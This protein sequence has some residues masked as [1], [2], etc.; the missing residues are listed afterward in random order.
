ML[1]LLMGIS[2]AN[3]VQS[4]LN[5]ARKALKEQNYDDLA[6]Q[7]KSAKKLAGKSTQILT[8]EQVSDIWFL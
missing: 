5:N 8:P 6:K 1:I 7:L 3:D 2:F 4:H